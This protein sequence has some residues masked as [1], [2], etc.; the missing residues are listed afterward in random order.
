MGRSNLIVNSRERIVTG[1]AYKKKRLNIEIMAYFSTKNARQKL[2][3]NASY[4]AINPKRKYNLRKNQIR[5]RLITS[6]LSLK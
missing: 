2:P 4:N 1:N 3:Q 5:K 6:R